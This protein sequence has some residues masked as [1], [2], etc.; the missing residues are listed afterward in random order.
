MVKPNMTTK[1]KK[2][3]L[4]LHFL[5]P[6]PPPPPAVYRDMSPGLRWCHHFLESRSGRGKTR[7]TEEGNSGILTPRNQ[8]PRETTVQISLSLHR[9]F[10]V[11]AG[12]KPSFSAPWG[13]GET[14]SRPL[15]LCFKIMSPLIS[16][17]I[18]WLLFSFY[19]AEL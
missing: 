4:K 7:Y 16:P 8:V 11:S 17:G 6:P 14:H 1:R 2:P 10:E 13:Q 19:N 3:N 12:Q 5:Y 15:G 18:G 9:K